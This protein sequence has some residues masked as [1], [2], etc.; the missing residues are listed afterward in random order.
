MWMVLKGFLHREDGLEMM[1]IAILAALVTT[2]AAVTLLGLGAAVAQGY[3][4]LV[5]RLGLG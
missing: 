2:T 4:D 1:E 3:Q 5:V